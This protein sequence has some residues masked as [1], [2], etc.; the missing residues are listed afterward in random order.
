[1]VLS[2]KMAYRQVIGS[3]MHN[4]ILFL[5]YTDIFPTDF[6]SK[7][8]RICFIS[9]QNLFSQGARV[10]TP[11][12]VDQEI[13]THTN[14]AIIYQQ[15]NGLDFLKI[16]Y[17]FAEPNN[18][19]LYYIRL[20]KYSLLRRL[21]KEGY[22][23]SEYY[24]ADKDVKNPLEES[25][26]QIHF[27]EAS[28]L[29]ILNSVE[30]K[31]NIIRNDF[32]QGGN[33]NGDA[34]AGIDELIEELR[35][36]PNIGPSLEGHIFSS[37]CR[38]ARQGCFYL[39]N[40]SSNVGKTRTSVF[41]ACHICY[42]IRWSHT[43]QTF[44]RE[45]DCN[46]KM[47]DP[48][49]ILFIVTEMDQSELQTIILAYLSGVNETKI[50]TGRYEIGE[51]E[52]VQFAAKIM[53]AYKGYFMIEA[54]SEP[55]L[56]NI[57]ATIKKYATIDNVKYVW[58]DYIHATGSLLNQFNNN[59]RPDMTLMM[60]A[61]QLKQLA[62]DYQI[63]VFSATQVNATGMEDNGE[64]KN[65]LSIRDAKSI[66]DKSDMSFVMSKVSDKVWNTLLPEWRKAVR[67]GILDSKYVEDA[68][69]RPTHVLDIYKM[70]RGRYKNVRIWIYLD[71]GTGERRDL[72]ITTA[73]NQ[74]IY[75]PL[76]LFNSAIE[77]NFSWRDYFDRKD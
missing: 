77:E 25:K 14:S 51:L 52:R 61:N 37:A 15:E 6:D 66:N 74:P 3:L 11:I 24:I 55:N 42:P 56:T 23:V 4:P 65:E 54:I 22:D 26:I 67:T 5:S 46:G 58:F 57:E 16:A 62:K 30:S 73:D 43:Q 18:F 12:E 49:K 35:Q 34:S 10:L 21:V 20:K 1:M 53:K 8:I 17:E 45:I 29:D 72:F 44:I 40:S 38:G 27:D 9:I 2:D 7:V 75:E 13:E 41:D 70:R 33:S 48:R 31:Y 63:F 59:V 32:L 60:L 19:D 47:R 36:T 69:Y 64:F 76:D 28:L 39:K 50:L 68:R 71:L